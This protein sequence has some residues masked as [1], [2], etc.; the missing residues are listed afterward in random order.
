MI[1]LEQFG[2]DQQ[3]SNLVLNLCI[4]DFQNVYFIDNFLTETIGA[5][6]ISQLL[7]VPIVRESQRRKRKILNFPPMLTVSYFARCSAEMR[8]TTTIPVHW[9]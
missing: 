6:T 1:P 4:M 2:P 7:R 5:S 3:S 9:P 8:P